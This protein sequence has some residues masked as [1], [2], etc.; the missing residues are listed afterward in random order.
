MAAPSNVQW[1]DVIGSG[2]GQGKIGAY[3]TS[4][5]TPTQ[6]TVTMQVWFWTKYSV[7]DSNNTFHYSFTGTGVIDIGSRN[8]QHPSNS[9][10]WSTDNQTHI[11]TYSRTYNRG[12]SAQTVECAADFSGIATINGSGWVDVKYTIP[13]LNKYTI[14]Y[15][16]NGGL[17]GSSNRWTEQ[18]FY[19]TN[20]VTQKNFFTRQG[21]TF[22]GWKES[23][24]TDWTKWI[25]KPWK[26]TYE[27]DVNLYAQWKINQYNLTFDAGTNGGLVLPNKVARKTV[28]KDYRDEIGTLPNAE[29][30]NY[31]LVDWNYSSDGSGESVYGHD[32]ILKDTTVFAQF[33][34]NANCYVK[35]EG[36]YKLGMM[37]IKVDGK[38]KTG[39]VFVKQ[40]GKY[41][42][43]VP[44]S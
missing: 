11:G 15:N 33:K 34:L 18:V 19:G 28:K 29:K 13:A 6:T 42:K 22:T 32:L 17:W 4:S 36:K 2:S 41:V 40:N 27:R 43:S 26:W 39:I 5:S 31:K 23:N 8:I 1:G 20:Y 35:S 21:Y 25:G 37:Y 24:G 14:A 12:T 38:Y 9:G 3:V 7:Y 30:T 10:G 16:G 44:N